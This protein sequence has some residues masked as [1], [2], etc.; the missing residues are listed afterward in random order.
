MARHADGPS[1]SRPVGSRPRWRWSCLCEPA[2]RWSRD[3][4]DPEISLD[5]SHH[6]F[7]NALQTSTPLSLTMPIGP[8]T[9]Q[10]AGRPAQVGDSGPMVILISGKPHRT[11]VWTS[12]E[13]VSLGPLVRHSLLC[14]WI[15]RCCTQQQTRPSHQS[16]PSP[17]S[18]VRAPVPPI[19]REPDVLPGGPC[20]SRSRHLGI[21]SQSWRFSP[22]ISIGQKC[23]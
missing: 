17:F 2:A 19:H 11:F 5:K 7:R 21:K 3:C 6:A 12:P 15:S 16:R 18:R 13:L 10:L 22:F 1:W 8:A 23:L 4:D 9:L 20:G 14:D